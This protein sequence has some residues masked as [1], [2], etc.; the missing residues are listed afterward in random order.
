M[1][2][3]AIGGYREEA[4]YIYQQS[5]F[6]RTAIPGKY[7]VSRATAGFE[8]GAYDR[9]KALIIDPTLSF[10]TYFGGSGFDAA[11]A[12]AVD[13]TGNIYIAGWTESVDFPVQGAFQSN[14]AGGVDAFVAKMD[15][16]GSHLF[17]C[18][19][20][21]GSAEDRA[22]GIAVDSSGNAYI[23]G[24]T[25]STNFPV[26]G[27]AMQPR[28]GGGRDA[29]VAK[30]DG[31]GHLIYSTYLGGSGQDTGT[32]IAVDSLGDVY[33]SGSTTSTNFPVYHP[34]QSSSGG[35]Q[36]AFVAELNSTGTALL[37][38]TF[39]GGMGDE[40]ANAIALDSAGKVYVA[41]D[42]NSPN[43]PTVN[44]LQPASGGNQ[45]AFVAKLNPAAGSL[46]YSTYLG[47]NGGTVGMPES[48]TAIDVDASGNAYV[49]GVTSSPNFPLANAFRPSLNG[50]TDA[51]LVKLAPS[52][53]ALA[54]GTFLGGSSAEVATSVR[55][56]STG[57]ACVAGYTAS[58]DFPTSSAVQS[59][60]AG[61][62]DAFLSCF[63]ADGNSLTFSTYLGGSGSDAAFGMALSGTSVYLAGQ[64]T[65][66][67]FPLKSAVQTFNGGS[68][69][70]FVLTFRI[71]GGLQFYP[72]TPCR[73]AD[74][75]SYGGKGGAFGP[76]SMAGET[77]RSFPVTSATCG[78]PSTAVAYSLNVTA[79]PFGYLG[80]LS[81]WS[82]GQPVPATSLLNSWNGAVVS[83]AAIIPAGTEGSISMMV[84]DPSDVFF[85]IN[86]YFAPSQPSGLQFYPV[87]PCRLVDTRS[88]EG[89]AGA[90]GPPSL[91]GGATRAFPVTAS[92]CG[93]PSNALAYSLNLTALPYGYLG[94][95]TA[96]PAGQPFPG[97]STLN[98]WGGTVVASATVV[99]AGLG[100]AINI[101]SSDRT[102]V[103]LDINGYFAPPQPS[104]LQFYA[105]APCRVADTRSGG[106]KTGAFGPPSIVGWSARALPVTSSPCGVPANAQ[107]Y[108]L[109]ITVVPHSYL[110]FLTV[111]PGGQP[112][113]VVSTLNSWNGTAV[114]NTAIVSAG[115]GG[116]ID[117]LASDQTDIIVDIYGYLAQ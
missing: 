70:A 74:T 109:N 53:N 18:T 84:S 30:M 7:S 59:S 111:W 102:D 20:L 45:D 115:V 8:V 31:S 47:G 51:F 52:G 44:A 46:I 90:F 68:Y 117:I 80:Y 100:G 37:F 12:I 1:I 26:R 92:P 40:N 32:G 104:G 77:P 49:A 89:K 23:T 33:L 108:V 56:D 29:F 76:P 15:P 58:Q 78:I 85:D 50:F 38:S 10:S 3:T 11:N 35:Q 48:A 4:P 17:Y 25:N 105:V 82:T 22:L 54:Y 91:S 103:I 67:D 79:V 55:A 34:A 41:G 5:G 16:T 72:V 65:S 94:F 112:F 86:G 106:G 61:G 9:T 60:N 24:W 62:Y 114:A 21:G 98:S 95:L 2:A 71:A 27:S 88:D 43:F 116:A 107:A 83:N 28:S 101:Y 63:A 93:I 39:L 73:V 19:Y 99:P 69:G 57:K 87:T 66:T 13:A 97:T 75:R 113:P 6:E 81:V 64:T 14:S 36:D 42:T 110:G 96:S